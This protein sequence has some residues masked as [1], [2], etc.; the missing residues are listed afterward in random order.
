VEHRFES[1]PLFD[2]DDLPGAA[3]DAVPFDDAQLAALRRAFAATEYG[4]VRPYA[5]EAPFELVVDGRLVRGRI[6]AVYR[7]DAGFE[8]VDY[9]TG[10]KPRDMAAAAWQLGV[11][12]LAWAALAGVPVTSVTAAFLYVASGELVRPPLLGIDALAELLGA[13]PAADPPRPRSRI[14][15]VD[16]APDL[17]DVDPDATVPM[18]EATSASGGPPPPG[19]RPSAPAQGPESPSPSPLPEATRRSAVATADDQLTLDW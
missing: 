1:R 3:D 2:P 18:A 16:D 10:L 5:V 11:Y 17:V 19:G 6:D 9:K 13:P 7:T 8:V 15:T 14:T 12:R 4:D